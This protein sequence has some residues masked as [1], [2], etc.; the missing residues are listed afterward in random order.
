MRARW[1]VGWRQMR[2]MNSWSLVSAYAL[3]ATPTHKFVREAVARERLEVVLVRQRR[4]NAR[5]KV[6][7]ERI[8][9]ERKVAEPLPRRHV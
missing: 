4:D 7:H 2:S 3:A 6:A 9:Q 5:R 1:S 8:V